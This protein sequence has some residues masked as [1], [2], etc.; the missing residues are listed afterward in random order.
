M[1]NT[2]TIARNSGWSGIDSIVGAI[3]AISTSIAIAAI[4]D[5]R[6]TATSSMYR[7]LRRW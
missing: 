7:I 2:K 5:L 3:V 4:S 1:S 6:R